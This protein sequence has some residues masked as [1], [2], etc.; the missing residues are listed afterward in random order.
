MENWKVG[1]HHSPSSTLKVQRNEQYDREALKVG[2]D[3]LMSR[4]PGLLQL[5]AVG[6][7]STRALNR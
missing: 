6:R 3:A 4:D 7:P 2:L 5:G 1:G